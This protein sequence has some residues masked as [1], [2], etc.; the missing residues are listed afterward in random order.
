MLNNIAKTRHDLSNI[1][2]LILPN[3][4]RIWAFGDSSF[5][6]SLVKCAR[7]LDTVLKRAECTP[8]SPIHVGAE[9]KKQGNAFMGCQKIDNA[10]AVLYLKDASSSSI[11]PGSDHQANN[12]GRT[13]AIRSFQP[14]LCAKSEPSLAVEETDSEEGS[15]HDAVESTP[16]CE[17]DEENQSTGWDYTDSK[18]T[19]LALLAAQPPYA[20]AIWSVEDSMA[21]ASYGELHNLAL[22]RDGV[23]PPFVQSDVCVVTYVD[24]GPLAATIFVLVASHAKFAPL[25]PAASRQEILAALMQLKPAVVVVTVAKYEEELSCMIAQMDKAPA[26]R[27]VAPLN[28]F[29]GAFEA[30]D[31]DTFMLEE[32]NEHKYQGSND[33]A[34][35]LRTSGTTS[36]PKVVPLTLGAI[37]RN[38]ATIASKLQLTSSDICINA[39][40]LFHIGALSASILATLASGGSVLCMPGFEPASFAKALTRSVAKPTYYSAVPTIHLALLRYVETLPGG[41]AGMGHGL[42]LIRSGAGK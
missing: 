15:F 27:I 31:K 32:K 10:S 22:D 33:V 41:A 26:L 18:D 28:T 7:E 2:R 5:D 21:P 38:G 29:A 39:M 9:L 40:P 25:S 34:L 14:S 3:Q 6:D 11:D 17:Q 35:L 37:V 24:E 1:L 8:I 19:I 4:L 23:L 30:R 42:R 36:H 13:R 20:P 12:A 16:Y